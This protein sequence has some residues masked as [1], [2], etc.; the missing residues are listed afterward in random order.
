MVLWMPAFKIIDLKGPWETMELF[1]LLFLLV[2]YFL[3]SGIAGARKSKG[4]C[5]IFFVNFLLGWTII[6]W[7]AALALAAASDKKKR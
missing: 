5:L 3:P 6:G 2:L 4:G 7:I 1:F